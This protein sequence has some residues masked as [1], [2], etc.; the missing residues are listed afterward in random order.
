MCN[1]IGLSTI[2]FMQTVRYTK[3]SQ[4]INKERMT[5]QTKDRWTA[6]IEQR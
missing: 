3:D 5:A 2:D 6:I 4:A 1:K